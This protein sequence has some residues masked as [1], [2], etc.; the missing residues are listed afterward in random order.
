MKT[1]NAGAKQSS[2]VNDAVL[3]LFPKASKVELIAFKNDAGIPKDCPCSTC[4]SQDRV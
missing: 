3:K 1:N 4:A 2:K